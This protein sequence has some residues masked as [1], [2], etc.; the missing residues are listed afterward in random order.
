[1]VK[2]RVDSAS[3]MEDLGLA[4]AHLGMIADSGIGVQIISDAINEHTLE[5]PPLTQRHD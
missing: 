5:S 1:M 2:I 3:A 4:W